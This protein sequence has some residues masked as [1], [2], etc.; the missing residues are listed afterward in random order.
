VTNSGTDEGMLLLDRHP[1]P[2]EAEIIR[3]FVRSLEP[4][5]R[6]AK[7]EEAEGGEELTRARAARA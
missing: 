4:M 1:T 3:E 5:A 6:E 2:E 7:N